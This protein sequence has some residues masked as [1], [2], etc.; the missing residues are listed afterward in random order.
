MTRRTAAGDLLSEVV[1]RILYA[2]GLLEAAGDRMADAGGGQTT[3]RWRVLAAV[4]ERPRT[5]S[6]IARALGLKRQSVQRTS[7][8]LAAEGL[9]EYR[10]NPDDRRAALLELSRA[11]A[12]ALA[13]IQTEQIAWANDLGGRIGVERLKTL[14]SALAALTESLTQPPTEGARS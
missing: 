9:A 12:R 7:D 11:G 1:V 2:S 6:S 14:R 10:E 13:A 8:L 4:E 5:V 3:A